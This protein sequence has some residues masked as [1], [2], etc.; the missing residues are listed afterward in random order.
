MYKQNLNAGLWQQHHFWASLLEIFQVVV[1]LL[2]IKSK[3]EW[4]EI[5]TASSRYLNDNYTNK[6][7]NIWLRH[8]NFNIRSILCSSRK[9]LHPHHGKNFFGNPPPPRN[10]HLGAT[11]ETPLPTEISK[12][13][14]PPPPP[15]RKFHC[16]D[17][18]LSFHFFERNHK[19]I[20]L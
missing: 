20:C 2:F 12:A 6:I 17:I 8:N 19:R 5:I 15:L 4:D 10:S 3:L 16:F 14:C 13:H 11:G 18:F 7:V 9:Y 1:V